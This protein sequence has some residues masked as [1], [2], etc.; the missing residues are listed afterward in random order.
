MAAGT[1]S[2]GIGAGTVASDTVASDIVASDIV[3]SETVTVEAVAAGIDIAVTVPVV[4]AFVVRFAGLI[5]AS[6]ASDAELNGIVVIVVELGL[7]AVEGILVARLDQAS[8]G[9]AMEVPIVVST[10][11]HRGTLCR[12]P[13]S[14]K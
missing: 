3:A 6:G 5:G 1:V 12:E 9:A 2:V 8:V 10:W 4:V 14:L 13:L 11:A 7:A